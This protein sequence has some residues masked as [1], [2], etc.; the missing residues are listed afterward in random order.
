MIV[1]GHLHFVPLTLELFLVHVNGNLIVIH[2]QNRF[3]FGGSINLLHGVMT[4]SFGGFG[5]N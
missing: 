1:A 3:L 2:D 5:I 4:W